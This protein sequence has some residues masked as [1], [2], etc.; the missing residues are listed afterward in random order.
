MALHGSIMVNRHEIG[1]WQARRTED[2]KSTKQV[3]L[4]EVRVA[5][6]KPDGNTEEAT[7]FMEHK[8]SDGA[9][10]LAGSVL[11]WAAERFPAEATIAASGA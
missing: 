11:T 6:R 1:H 10:V 3:S 2:L 8:Y 7:C 4:Y 5:V 9:L